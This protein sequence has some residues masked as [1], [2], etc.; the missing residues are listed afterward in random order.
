M[1]EKLLGVVIMK[2]SKKFIFI[3]KSQSLIIEMEAELE[4]I[5]DFFY[6]ILGCLAEGNKQ[7][8]QPF[9]VSDNKKQITIQFLSTKYASNK[10]INKLINFFSIIEKDAFIYFYPYNKDVDE[11]FDLFKESLAYYDRGCSPEEIEANMKSHFEEYRYTKDVLEKLSYTFNPIVPSHR[12]VVG[13]SEKSKRKCIYCGGFQGD[14]NHTTFKE[15]AHAI[16]E[17]LGNKKFIQN[18]ECDSCNSF[19]SEN[20]EEDLSNMLM[21]N[22]LKYGIK[23]KNGY[24]IFQIGP[25][26]YVRYFD[27]REEDYQKDWGYFEAAKKLVRQQRAVCPVA[28]DIG[29][30]KVDNQICISNIKDYCPMHAY[31]ALVKCVIGLIGNDKLGYFKKTIQWLRYDNSYH[32]LPEVAVIKSNRLI[33]E[34]ELYIFER[35]EISNY[36][37]P[38]CYGEIRITD[39]IFVFVIPFCEQDRKKFRIIEK[40]ISFKKILDSMYGNYELSDFSETE[41]KQVEKTFTDKIE[42]KV[43]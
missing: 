18:E 34:P 11:M 29:G 27:W 36:D 22:R 4:V 3:K 26:K 5:R 16:P 6:G 15:K 7:S 21:F 42:I 38:F 8:E 33:T 40:E 35:K 17:A 1:H 20:A 28:V 13:E 37:L 32:K 23:G 9:Q 12:V 41:S 30:T 19:F 14:R 39:Q 2:V 25:R 31:K 43:E 10:R 24:P